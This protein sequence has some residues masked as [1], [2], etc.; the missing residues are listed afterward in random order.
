MSNQLGL[1]EDITDRKKPQVV[2]KLPTNIIQ[3]VSGG[4]HS[5]CLTADGI[6]YTFGCNDEFALGRILGG[7]VE[8]EIATTP[9]LFPVSKKVVK[10][11]SGS[12]H[13]AVLTTTG[14]VYT[15]GNAEQGQLG[16]VAKYSAVR[17]GRRGSS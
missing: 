13:L 14:E 5:V 2:K 9:F 15:A 3:A 8:K 7:E 16:R 4:M 11:S 12:D 1:G 17:G 10:I 6:V